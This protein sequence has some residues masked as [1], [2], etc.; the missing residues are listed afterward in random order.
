M[1]FVNGLSTD[2]P[3]E[4][5]GDDFNKF[6]KASDDVNNLS[7]EDQAEA[8][9]ILQEQGVGE[10]ARFVA[11]K[12]VAGGAG[13]DEGTLSSAR[14]SMK[15]FSEGGFDRFFRI[16]DLEGI[17]N[18]PN[19]TDAEIAEAQE[20][21][22]TLLSAGLDVDATSRTVS[23]KP[24]ADNVDLNK[25]LE[26]VTAAGT[27]GADVLNLEQF[28]ELKGL[29]EEVQT[30]IKNVISSSETEKTT[31][32]NEFDDKMAAG[33]AG[34]GIFNDVGFGIGVGQIPNPPPNISNDPL[35]N[36]RWWLNQTMARA[37][38][39][40]VHPDSKIM[41]KRLADK[42][43]G[44][45]DDAVRR[46]EEA[47]QESIGKRSRFIAGRHG[48][49]ITGKMSEVEFALLEQKDREDA[50]RAALEAQQA[51]DQKVIDDRA[52][53]TKTTTTALNKLLAGQDLSSADL[54]GLDEDTTA[55]LNNLREQSVATEIRRRETTLQDRARDFEDQRFQRE[56]FIGEL[57]RVRGVN[58]NL[59]TDV[60]T[61]GMTPGGFDRTLS[62]M[63]KADQGVAPSEAE[64]FDLTA[65][66]RA[67]VLNLAQTRNNQL[68]LENANSEVQLS[69][70]RQLLNPNTVGSGAQIFGQ[71]N[72]NQFF[73]RNAMSGIEQQIA[74]QSKSIQVN[75]DRQ[76]A[77]EKTRI[78]T[79]IDTAQEKLAR[80]F[81]DP[82]TGGLS[83]QAQRKF[84]ELEAGRASAL[85]EI[86]TRVD[87]QV[88]E[89][90]RGNMSLLLG[91]QESREGASVAANQINQ[92]NLG[93]IL[94]F[95]Q[96]QEQLGLQRDELGFQ[97]EQ[98][99]GRIGDES[100][101][102]RDQF[103]SQS[104]LA[105]ES[106]DLEAEIS[107]AQLGLQ[108][109][110]FGLTS[111]IQRGQ[112]DLASD[113]QRG[114]LGL[115]EAELFGST[116]GMSA[117]SLGVDLASIMG[118]DG[119]LRQSSMG[120][121]GV[122]VPGATIDEY[123]RAV[124]DLEA[125]FQSSRGRMPTAGELGSLMS[126]GE[127]GGRKTLA[128]AQA[129]RQDNLANK[130][131]DL[132]KGMAFGD[133]LGYMRDPESGVRV[134]TLDGMAND[135]NDKQLGETVRQFNSQ[136]FGDAIDPETGKVRDGVDT[137]E[138]QQRVVEFNRE[139]SLS[140][141][142]TMASVQQSWAQIT[143]NTGPGPVGATELGIDISDIANSP[144]PPQAL[145]RTNEATNVRDAFVAMSGRDPSDD[146][147]LR[148]L[149]GETL[150]VPGAPTLAAREMTSRI[151]QSNMDRAVTIDQIAKNNDLSWAQVNQ[152]IEEADRQWALTTQDVAEITGIDQEQWVN[153]RNAWEDA[154]ASGK[155]PAAA[156][157]AALNRS[158]LSDT[159]F[160]T[161]NKLF[162]ER[163]GLAERQAAINIGM[164]EDQWK[165]TSDARNRMEDRETAYWEGIMEG[166]G[167]DM[168]LEDVI[169]N[170]PA[171]D[172]DLQKSM[173][174][175]ISN[176]SQNTA[177]KNVRADKKAGIMNDLENE[178]RSGTETVVE[179]LA[180]IGELKAN[181]PNGGRNFTVDDYT[182]AGVPPG[183]ANAL[184]VVGGDIDKSLLG[185]ASRM[186][187]A[188]NAGIDPNNLTTDQVK[189]VFGRM[190][191]TTLTD[192]QAERILNNGN[193]NVVPS[194]WMEAF[195][196][197]ERAEILA[198]I[199]GGTSF[200]IA[201]KGPGLLSTIGDFV[202]RTV[203]AAAPTV[204][205]S[206]IGVPPI[207]VP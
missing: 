139:M 150:Q 105:Q 81:A 7:P 165:A 109:D 155:D 128:Q 98:A 9:R 197:H 49:H 158:T 45:G 34:E 46:I 163:F 99:L 41:V 144:L 55:R 76:R 1:D 50:E 17:I 171:L 192:S 3:A 30:I 23:A 47:F 65:D 42:I 134:Q 87:A 118:P 38:H 178:L 125:G 5:G 132:E 8:Q 130:S 89:E 100:T 177:W 123:M 200:Q 66:Q 161:A 73:G 107:R 129:D 14:S 121:D 127:I 138:F 170:L 151:T 203:V 32:G 188:E 143:G 196:P 92:S 119:G 52:A 148:I 133:R 153:A 94:G 6:F 33:L 67:Q 184:A 63:E 111:D 62:T 122:L 11:G 166:K 131:F 15:G 82:S 103:A 172:G 202:G 53:A 106:Q 179:A 93:H 97:R 147:V 140:E 18:D 120:Q 54:A 78:N 194:D 176:I 57:D 13:F 204:A 195:E 71:G 142:Q 191:Q 146:E 186:S 22:D 84:E 59:T 26:L 201:S 205:R 51:A 79:Q 43:T 157:A 29:S 28:V 159:E 168:S 149:Q 137:K 145:L 39:G 37:R 169:S 2:K 114:Q 12:S 187:N 21:R 167:K 90:T 10:F 207:P 198:L 91:L 108:R 95:S 135:R 193:V 101:L 154:I 85:N 112:L 74:E 36:L 164:T 124:T 72:A 35:A 20:E 182:A 189:E 44:S 80:I 86:D 141:R 60:A 117:T 115:A 4:L 113:I 25:A 199:N 180:T 88:R 183:I 206:L 56:S 156:R 69:A 48:H 16:A 190:W 96:G 174:S 83:G 19:S 160:T 27:S 68:D 64:L 126:G 40:V 102:A 70:R 77:A 31:S 110:Q 24:A 75:A 104:G 185:I 175:E 116:E 58:E 152:G 181:D 162:E 173:D 136:F 61:V